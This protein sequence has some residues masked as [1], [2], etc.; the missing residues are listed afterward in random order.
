[1]ASCSFLPTCVQSCELSCRGN[2]SRM[3]RV[4][5]EKRVFVQ[6]QFR[7]KSIHSDCHRERPLLPVKSPVLQC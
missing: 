5:K 7:V 4:D 3:T 2:E 6:T 1:M